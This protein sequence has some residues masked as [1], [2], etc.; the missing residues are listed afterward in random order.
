MQSC[1]CHHSHDPGHFYFPFLSFCPF[2]TNTLLHPALSLTELF[3]VPVVPL[4]KF[5]TI[6][7]VVAWIKFVPFSCWILFQDRRNAVCLYQWKDVCFW[8]LWIKL[9][10]TRAYQCESSQY[11][12]YDIVNIMIHFCI[13][14]HFVIATKSQHTWDIM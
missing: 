9:L 13:I 4:V 5:F 10:E 6:H 7:S 1:F 3:L 2:A 12:L 8:W 11:S 14:I